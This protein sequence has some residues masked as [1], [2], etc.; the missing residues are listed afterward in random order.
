MTFRE[1][2]TLARSAGVGRLVLTHFSPSVVDPAAFT[3]NAL[4]EFGETV[5]G[6]DGLT[7][8]LRFRTTESLTVMLLR[9]GGTASAALAESAVVSIRS[10][11]KGRLILVLASLDPG[12]GAL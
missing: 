11:G 1:A 6:H 3:E 4:A 2:G 8:S 12:Q 7:L 9:Y 10:P 5:V